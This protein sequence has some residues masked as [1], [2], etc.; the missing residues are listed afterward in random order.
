MKTRVAMLDL[1][2]HPT[3]VLPVKSEVA[4]DIERAKATIV[5]Y[6]PHFPHHTLVLMGTGLRPVFV[7]KSELAHQLDVMGEDKLPWK[8]VEL[9]PG[10]V[11]EV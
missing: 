10:G 1:A 7:G 5:K 11:Q 6:K 2:G 4:E 3:A 9:I 8:N